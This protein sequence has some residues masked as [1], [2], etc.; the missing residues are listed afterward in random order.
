[1]NS[2]III[3]LSFLTGGGITSLITLRW[4][5]KTKKI[6]YTDKAISF[7]EK[8]YDE[9]VRKNHELS[10]RVD[11]LEKMIPLVCFVPDCPNRLK[12]IP[13]S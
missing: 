9:V 3:L 11:A 2:I 7:I 10:L 5:Y 6:D 13:M 8:Q 4:F 12:Q 1:M